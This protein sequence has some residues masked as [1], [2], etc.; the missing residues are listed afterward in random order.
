MGCPCYSSLLPF[1]QRAA[2]VSGVGTGPLCLPES[3]RRDGAAPVL[4]G[5]SQADGG[6]AGGGGLCRLDLKKL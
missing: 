2:R 3:P 6:L 5:L 1:D 4:L